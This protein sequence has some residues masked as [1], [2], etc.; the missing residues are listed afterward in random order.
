VCQSHTG[1][2]TEFWF[3]PN[4]PKS[5]IL[6]NEW[7]NELQKWYPGTQFTTRDSIKKFIKEPATWD[8]EA[9]IKIHKNHRRISIRSLTAIH[10]D[11]NLIKVFINSSSPSGA[12]ARCGLWLV[13]KYLSI[14][15]YLSP[16]LSI[17]SLPT[18]E[19][20]F[21]LLLSIF[22]WVFLFVS[23]LPV[24]EWRSFG[25]S[26]PPLSPGDPASLSFAPLS[27]LL[28]FLLYLTH[29]VLDSS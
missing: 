14:C 13:E 2:L 8:Y 4:R 1:R 18:F 20:L 22:S 17:F 26:Y 16:T 5:W 12:T 9:P 24:L 25:A 28:Y 11:R 3:L 23:S 15:P 21:P 7:M 27:I 19:D 6:M 10:E 29:L